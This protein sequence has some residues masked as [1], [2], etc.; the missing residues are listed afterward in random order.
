MS[1]IYVASEAVHMHIIDLFASW[2]LKG[3]EIPCGL[4]SR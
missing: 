1:D 4:D 3:V 2:H